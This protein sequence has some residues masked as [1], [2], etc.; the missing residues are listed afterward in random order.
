MEQAYPKYTVL[1]PHT[2]IEKVENIEEIV[3]F[4][5]MS[6]PALALDGK[7]LF[8][9]RVPTVREIAELVRSASTV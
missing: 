2:A 5:V 6:T 9:G 8:T 7:I 4:G 1:D 3:K